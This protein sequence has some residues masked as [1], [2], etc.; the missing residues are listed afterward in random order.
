MPHH[1]ICRALL[2]LTLLPG[3]STVAEEWHTPAEGGTPARSFQAALADYD[4]GRFAHA[5]KMLEKLQATGENS[6]ELHE[7]LGMAYG[8]Q[9]ED[10]K[11]VEQLRQAAVLKPESLTAK[12]NLAT[13][14]VHA[15]N[16]SA[17]EEQCLQA[18]TI[19]PQDYGANR[20]LAELYLR[21]DN[22]ARALPFLETAQAARPAAADNG[23]DLS[24]ALLMQKQ[25]AKA[26][27]LIRMLQMQQ[28]SGELHSLLGRIDEQ[29]GNFLNAASEFATA[30]HMD[31]T[32]DNLFVWASELLLHRAYEAAIMVFKSG[33][34]RFPASPRLWTGLGM[35]EYSRG[36][37]PDAISSLLKAADLKPDDPR[38]YLF[39]SKA[40]LSSP[41]QAED[42]I[43]RFHR[44]ASLEPKNA[45]AQYYYAISLWKGKRL[46]T[47]EVD[48][49]SAEALLQRS[50]ALDGTIAETHLQLGILY[51]DEQQYEK[52]L[53]EYQRAIQ[54]DPTSADAHFRLGRYYLHAGEKE[55]AQVELQTFKA[56]QAE[57]HK[58]VDKERASVQQFVIN[59]PKA[60]S[61]EP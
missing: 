48:Y 59:T 56:L 25:Y 29:Q 2:G 39:L 53:P 33:T 12:T 22:L 3:V 1:F 10:T 13:A 34:E 40:Y 57:H 44:Y 20:M 28:D 61:T 18:L 58:K 8:A 27:Q 36:E 5:A 31:P 11:A 26:S 7:L 51:N 52:S 42:V 21:Q 47:P 16:F 14:L 4:A 50:I 55:R 45:L 24:L 49:K 19:G 54:L 9:G 30:A 46:E 32:E 41:S 23:Y 60:T 17:A 38:C 15:G 6:F 37:Y 43:S 35:A